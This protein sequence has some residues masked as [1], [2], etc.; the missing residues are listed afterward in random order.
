MGSLAVPTF[1]SVKHTQNQV[2]P[3]SSCQQA[4]GWHPAFTWWVDREEPASAL[5][6]LQ[7]KAH[8]QGWAQKML[9]AKKLP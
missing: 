8:S 2:P 1:V 3:S 6:A 9:M 4:K 5:G 7:C